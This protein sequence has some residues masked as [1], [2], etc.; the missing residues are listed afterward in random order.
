GRPATPRRGAPGNEVTRQTPGYVNTLPADY[1]R[2]AYRGLDYYYW[3][4][5]YYYPYTNDGPVIYVEAP[6]VNGEPT[7]PPRPYVY[8]L[9]AGYKI[10]TFNGVNYYVYYSYY[11]YVYYINGRAVYVLAPVVNGV[12][13]VPPPPY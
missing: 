9:P 7:V 3:G 13:T 2:R 5:Y 4:G 11:Y 6:V 8:T 10:E 12:P 1:E